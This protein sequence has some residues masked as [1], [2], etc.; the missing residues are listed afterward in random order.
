VTRAINNVST[1]VNKIQSV[2]ITVLHYDYVRI[3][4]VASSAICHKYDPKIAFAKQKQTE[5]HTE[6]VI[7]T[8]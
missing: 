5:N 6:L 8:T 2:G 1:E 4:Q 7:R 3:L